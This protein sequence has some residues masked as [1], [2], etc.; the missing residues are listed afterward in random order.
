MVAVQR[1]SKKPL[2]FVT[3][4]FSPSI[5]LKAS[6]KSKEI[7]SRLYLD[8]KERH[9]SKSTQN[10]PRVTYEVL[11]GSDSGA[12]LRFYAASYSGPNLLVQT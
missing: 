4:G 10:D 6:Q 3:N 9:P 11:P 2:G 7:Y 5:A 8:Y 1:Y 12:P